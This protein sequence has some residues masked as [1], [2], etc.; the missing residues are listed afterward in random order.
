MKAII[1]VKALMI[2]LVSLHLT[3]C[4]A[5]R[6]SGDSN[7]DIGYEVIQL[8]SERFKVMFN[9]NNVAN[10]AEIAVWEFGDG[11]VAKGR[12]VNHIYYSPGSYRVRFEYHIDGKKH[13]LE[14][15]ILLKGSAQTLDIISR[16][17]IIID[18]DHND[19]NQPYSS[20][21]EIPQPL[22]ANTKLSGIMLEKGACQAG[23][24]CNIGDDIDRFAFTLSAPSS[25][26]LT[27]ISGQFEF[28]IITQNQHKSQ[29]T[30]VKQ[31]RIEHTSNS[32]TL[33]E[34]NYE[35]ILSR[36]SPMTR[37][38]IVISPSANMARNF[39]PG[40]LIV[41]W[42][43]KTQPELLDI[44]NPKLRQ[45]K[46][47]GRAKAALQQDP[48]VRSVSYNYWR[49]ASNTPYQWSL[50]EFGIPLMWQHF[51]KRGAGVNIAVID[52]GI[53]P[54]Y[55][56]T[57]LSHHSGFDFI[58]DPLNS[59][60]GDGRD[61]DPTDDIHSYHGTHVT[62]IIAA[63]GHHQGIEGISRASNIIPIRVLGKYGATSFDLINALLY[64]A[65]LENDSQQLP[66]KPADIINLSLGG[67]DY[68]QVEHQVIQQVLQQGVI[69]VAAAGNQN[70]AQLDYPARYAGV[71]SVGATNRMGE[72]A[73]Y[74]NYGAR[75]DIMAPGGECIDLNCINGIVN[76]GAPED[77]NGLLHLS[78]TS[79]ASAHAS[80]TLALLKSKLPQLDNTSILNALNNGE[81][82]TQTQLTSQT[83]WGQLSASHI[84]NFANQQQPYSKIWGP[85]SLT[86]SST[87]E[88]MQ[89]QSIKLTSRGEFDW[90][91]LKIEVNDTLNDYINIY[92][93][94]HE[95]LIDQ[96][97]TARANVTG[98]IKIKYINEMGQQAH[99]IHVSS[100]SRQ[101]KVKHLPYLYLQ[102]NQQP[103]SLRA[104]LSDETGWQ[105]TI[106]E[107][108]KQ[109]TVQASSDLDYDGIY[110]EPGEFC[111]QTLIE[112]IDTGSTARSLKN[113]STSQQLSGEL[114]LY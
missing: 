15:D 111:A 80:A 90:S 42:K 91:S 61:N 105:A 97:K 107:S 98:V 113:I 7:V 74:S 31:G 81:L 112:N 88:N 32:I 51:P 33:D 9:A 28:K 59:G 5:S 35:L 47:I 92:N 108:A 40:K 101:Q 66:D 82:T 77:Q 103:S 68:S 20:N 106:P 56:F 18:S 34:G 96:H 89:S 30:S 54:H 29:S 13:E 58:S 78:G 11:Y 36:L 57:G 37:Y 3:G 16:S 99:L 102:M 10:N 17:Q 24:L 70:S 85:N 12:S 49:H 73:S 43:D 23:R 64:A 60:D 27:Q 26:E 62:G 114:L 8:N 110:C 48:N 50:N 19:P 109:Q 14:K 6:S 52:S 75:L 87:K 69:V 79:M 76:L 38:G 65:G 72:R 95:I 44:G 25:I 104:L 71:I 46:N 41:H 22:T 86:L 100:D 93:Q 94:A 1:T 45:F 39:Q 84:I 53:A 21:N 63:Q 67:N 2:V 4:L 55:G 83:G